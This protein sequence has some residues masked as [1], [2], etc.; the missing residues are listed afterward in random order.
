MFLKKLDLTKKET[1]ILVVA[2]GVLI[3]AILA[4]ISLMQ[5]T[6]TDE[7]TDINFLG[8][9]FTRLESSVLVAAP[10]DDEPF[11]IAVTEDNE[12]ETY[13]IE[14]LI[15]TGYGLWQRLLRNSFIF[16]YLVIFLLVM[17]KK[18]ETQFHGIFKGV[19]IGS[20]F[21][22]LLF[23]LQLGLDVSSKLISFGHDFIHLIPLT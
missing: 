22:L 20:A 1:N 14:G 8:Y 13:S 11:E 3:I 16:F 19:L 15:R 4:V 23:T 18:K 7:S 10:V 17:W 5:P 6:L 21:V 12:H 9:Q 2:T